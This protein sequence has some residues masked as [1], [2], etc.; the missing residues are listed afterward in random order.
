MTTTKRST[1]NKDRAGRRRF[2]KGSASAVAALAAAPTII[3]SRRGAADD[4][5]VRILG[6]E[7][8][9]IAD[10]SDFEK[11]TGLKMEFT[12]IDSDPGLFMQEIVANEAGSDY[13]IFA[14]DGGLEDTLG[15]EG[16]FLPSTR[17]P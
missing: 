16:Y 9:A 11:D 4:N 8:V 12:G 6:V 14:F 5:V 15:P 13:D 10:W 7:T 17:T 1:T 3:T 2:L